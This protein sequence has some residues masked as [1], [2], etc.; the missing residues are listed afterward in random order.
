MELDWGGGLECGINKGTEDLHDIYGAGTILTRRNQVSITAINE[1]HEKTYVVGT[2]GTSGLGRV[3]VD[4]VLVGT[5]DRDGAGGGTIDPGDHGELRPW[6]YE[7]F[8]RD[9]RLSGL[10]GKAG[11]FI[12]DPLGG[13]FPCGRVVVAVV[14]CGQFVQVRL[15]VGR[16]K[17]CD[18]GIDVLFVG[19]GRD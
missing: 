19:W 10:R 14:E 9:S 4:R 11:E 3:Q 8:D 12:E 2:R 16:G 18:Q 1:D 17:V 15:H 6:V 13:F 5:E 7:F